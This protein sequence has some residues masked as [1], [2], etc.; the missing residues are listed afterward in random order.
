MVTLPIPAK[1]DPIAKTKPLY[2]G[3]DIREVDA[4]Y[5]EVRGHTDLIQVSKTSHQPLI[6]FEDTVVRFGLDVLPARGY[7]VGLIELQNLAY[8][9]TSIC[10]V[11]IVS[12]REYVIDDA[13]AR[14]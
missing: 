6:L 7:S 4:D 2:G 8:L 14:L 13:E 12:R 11:R 9:L 1:Y 10:S 3:A 5:C